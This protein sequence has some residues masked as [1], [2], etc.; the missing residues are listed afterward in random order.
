MEAANRGEAD[1]LQEMKTIK[2]KKKKGQSL[3]NTVEG[4]EGPDEILNKFREVYE[5]L[6]NSAESIEAMKAIK[7]NIA[8]LIDQDSVDEIQKITGK[9]LKEACCKMK[10]G[11]SD[12]SGVFTSDVL[13]HSPVSLFEKMAAVFRSFFV[14]GDVTL[15]LL[16]CAFLPLL[17]SSLK[18]PSKTD[19]YR[20]IAGS[21][22]ILKL[23]DNVVLL[24]WGNLLESVPYQFG[25]KPGTSTTECSWLVMEVSGHFLRNAPP[26]YP[27][28]LTAARCLTNA[29]LTNFF[30][31]C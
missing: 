1:L 9:V 12:V 26:L 17:K 18:D 8:R 4:A 19:S 14:H 29:S 21:S 31:N 24:L 13:L 7:T 25:F 28:Y 3:P 23:M 30:K 6:Y 10:P 20:A 15:E 2:G 22:Q 27:V 16:T 11:K 5:N